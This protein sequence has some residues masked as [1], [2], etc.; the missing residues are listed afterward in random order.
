MGSGGGLD[1]LAKKKCLVP[2]GI[3]QRTVQ[4]MA[5]DTE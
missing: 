2:G 5:E 1:F 3:L 4:P